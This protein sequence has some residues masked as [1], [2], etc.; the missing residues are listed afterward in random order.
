MHSRRYSTQLTGLNK[1]LAERR[2]Q[3]NDTPTAADVALFPALVMF[4]S[5]YYPLLRANCHLIGGRESPYRRLHEYVCD[6]YTN[7]GWGVA[8][9]LGAAKAWAYPHFGALAGIAKPRQ[10][11]SITPLAC[12]YRQ[13]LRAC[14]LYSLFVPSLWCLGRHC[15]ATPG[16]FAHI[17]KDYFLIK[18]RSHLLPSIISCLFLFRSLTSLPGPA[19]QSHAG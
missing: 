5:I 3:F 19:L 8:V 11:G 9:D 10:V 4:D 16:R 14:F 7:A 2:F 18:P 17:S 6:L 12:R 15:K 1:R 13:S